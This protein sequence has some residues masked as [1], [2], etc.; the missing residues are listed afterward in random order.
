MIDTGGVCGDI[1]SKGIETW[2]YEGVA[3]DQ[4]LT[5]LSEA[6]DGR[7][8]GLPADLREQPMLARTHMT[9][10]FQNTYRYLD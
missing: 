2:C 4:S 9:R 10:M 5:R 7:I 1:D 6:V 3:V 8:L